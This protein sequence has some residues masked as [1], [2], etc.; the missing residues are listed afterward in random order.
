LPLF[1][2]AHGLKVV[3]DESSVVVVG[4]LVVASVV[5]VGAVVVAAV[6]V[7]TSTVVPT[8]VVVAGVGSV[9]GFVFSG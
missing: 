4:T 8:V 3:T 5:V 2:P 7:V 6:V 1:M 9:I